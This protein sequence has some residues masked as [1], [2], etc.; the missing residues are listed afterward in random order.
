[1]AVVVSRCKTVL[2]AR[3]SRVWNVVTDVK[4]YPEWRSDVEQVEIPNDREFWEYTRGGYVTKFTIDREETEHRW[5]FTMDND[6]MTGRWVGVFR[7]RGK[8]TVADFTEYVT[9]KK[10]WMRPFVKPYLKRQ[11]ARFA[12]DLRAALERLQAGQ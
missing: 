5:E 8:A 6:N 2:P 10:F 3:L 12:A 9:A 11:Q 4:R 1:M 7:Q